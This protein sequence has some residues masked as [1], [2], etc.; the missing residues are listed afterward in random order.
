VPHLGQSR[1]TTVV[2]KTGKDRNHKRRKQRR[3]IECGIA[4]PEGR[5]RF[6][7]GVLWFTIR[8]GHQPMRAGLWL[9]ILWIIGFLAF[10]LGYQMQVMV[11]S[12]HIAYDVFV[13]KGVLPGHYPP[14]CALV[15][16]IDTSLPIIGFGQKDRWYPRLAEM[17]PP[18]GSNDG[19]SG[20]L[21][22][23]GITRRL[24][25]KSMWV[26]R[27]TLA[28]KLETYRWFHLA[29]GWFLATMVLAGISGLIGR[30]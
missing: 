30:E 25:P 9:V 3:T 27:A 24:D 1:Q 13:K 14:F 23:A 11:P 18:P 16:S 17:P 21:C 5:P 29:L 6:W 15:Y 22:K 2:A 10:G 28:T 4:T 26:S 12:E 8:N 20:L 19:I 7:Q